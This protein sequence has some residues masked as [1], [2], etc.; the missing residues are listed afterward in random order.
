MSQETV[1]V[2]IH[3][4]GRVEIHVRGVDGMACLTATQ[5]LAGLLGSQVIS[6]ELTAEAYTDSE[7]DHGNQ[8]WH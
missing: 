6:Q 2:S 7:L 5:E 1:E 8:Q 3:P 4:D